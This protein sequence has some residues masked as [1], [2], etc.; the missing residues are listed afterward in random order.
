MGW[1][2]LASSSNG[3]Y[4]VT[5]SGGNLGGTG[6]WSLISARTSVNWYH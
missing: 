3:Q 5:G 6:N 2:R 4:L 1:V